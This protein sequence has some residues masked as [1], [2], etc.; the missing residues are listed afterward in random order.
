[1]DLAFYIFSATIRLEFR[2]P[3]HRTKVYIPHEANVHRL[4]GSGGVP[5]RQ[6]EFEKQVKG[7]DGEILFQ[8]RSLEDW[9][10]MDSFEFGND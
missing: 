10:D 8:D 9:R 3:L 4:I 2:R 5:V 1:M 7:E 6:E